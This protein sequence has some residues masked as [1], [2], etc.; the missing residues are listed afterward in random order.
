MIYLLS[1]GAVVSIALIRFLSALWHLS[2]GTRGAF[3]RAAVQALLSGL[4]ACLLITPFYIEL[5]GATRD[6]P[7]LWFISAFA[8][9]ESLTLPILAAGA[10][11]CLAYFG[12]RITQRHSAATLAA[13]GVDMTYLLVGL[14]M[15][16]VVVDQITFFEPSKKDAGMV[17]WELLGEVAKVNDVHC[18]SPLLIVKG[19]DGDVA[20]YR[21]PNRAGIVLGRYSAKPFIPWPHYTEGE[22]LELAL[23]LRDITR[24]A[25]VIEPDAQPANKVRR[26]SE[27]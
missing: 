20:T 22:S 24:K 19:M 1:V 9:K 23:A 25:S 26:G 21:C 12:L 11:A 27:E 4:C 14:Y 7:L 13:V 10:L 16:F 8:G 5:A 17:N 2:Y 6:I 3:S 18:D 15:A